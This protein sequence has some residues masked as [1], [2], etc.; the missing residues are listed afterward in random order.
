MPETAIL[1]EVIRYV[2]SS[3]HKRFP[4]P[5]VPPTLRSDAS[6]CDELDPELSQD[7]AR[8]TRV[9]RAAMQ[10]GQVD[11]ILEGRFPRKVWGRIL[12]S[13]GAV[14]LF[15]A[16]LTNRE[17]GEYKGYFIA[18][19]DLVGKWAWVR[20]RVCEAGAWAGALE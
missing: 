15:E 10:R 2:G 3:E 19:D 9:L 20:A 5:L 8:L 17:T 12:L 16:R 13:T 14:G 7:P 18:E 11:R 4:N 6:D 1:A